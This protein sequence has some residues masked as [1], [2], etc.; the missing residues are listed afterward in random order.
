L[1]DRI[2]DVIKT[3]GE[4]VSS[5][6]LKSIISQHPGVA[7]VAVIGMPRPS[8]S[9]LAAFAGDRRGVSARHDEFEAHL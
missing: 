7:E 8:R 3:G 5:I 6:E 1:V 2:K 9:D 4:L